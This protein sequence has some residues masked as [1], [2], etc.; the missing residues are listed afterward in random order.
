MLPLFL[1]LITQKASA[2][3]PSDSLASWYEITEAYPD[4]SIAAEA[5]QKIIEFY[6]RARE[7]DKAKDA[8]EVV[9]GKLAI[10]PRIYRNPYGY[11]SASLFD[12]YMN[13]GD[14]ASAEE[15]SKRIQDELG[16]QPEL[17]TLP[18]SVDGM[19]DRIE[20][21]KER[22][23]WSKFLPDLHYNLGWFLI[24]ERR[25]VEAEST[26]LIIL[27][28]PDT[29]VTEDNLSDAYF[30]RGRVYV[31]TGRYV[32]A[33]KDFEFWLT[34]FEDSRPDLAPAILFNLGWS[35]YCFAEQEV[36][37]ETQKAH[38]E[39][40]LEAFRRINAKYRG[41]EFYP[42]ARDKITELIEDCQQRLQSQD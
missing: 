26:L 18:G 42:K 30:M 13:V 11:G 31:E 6:M 33:I 29:N 35:Y 41:S 37:A 17:L 9:K 7:I 21:I 40:A 1:C 5:W 23:P 3:Q 16:S 20:E 4:S 36:G 27:N 25:F 24:Q 14:T 2:T 32:D 10:N 38:Y 22:N 19:M 39:K 8:V 34:R 28:Q 15:Y 12:Y